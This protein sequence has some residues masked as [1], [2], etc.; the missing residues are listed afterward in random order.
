MVLSDTVPATAGEVARVPIQR[1]LVAIDLSH[2]SE[3]IL[4]TGLDA[5]R[6]FGAEVVVLHVF[7]SDEYE[8]QR[9]VLRTALDAYAETIELQI[10]HRLAQLPAHE[11]ARVEVVPGDG[12]ADQIIATAHRAQADLIVLGTH[13]RTG[14]PRVLMGSVAEA[15]LRH[16]DIPVLVVPTRVSAAEAEAA[17]AS[18]RSRS[19]RR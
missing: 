7:S 4:K 15:V 2:A 3:P 1:L 10:R 13:G 9:G 19:D 6:Q 14:L 5:A 8:D 17:H 11:K 18:D 16:S 12:V